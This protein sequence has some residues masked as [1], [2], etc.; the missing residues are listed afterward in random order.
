MFRTGRD[1]V[2]RRRLEA[3]A[4]RRDVVFLHRLLRK[5]D[6]ESAVRIQPRDLKRLVRALEVFFLTG[7]PLTAHF[8]E[9]SRRS[10][11]DVLAIGLRLPAER[12]PSASRARRR[13]V[14]RGFRRDPD[15]A[16]SGI[17]RPRVRSAVG[18]R[19]A[20]EPARRA[21]ELATRA[22]IAQETA[23]MRAGS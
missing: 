4:E 13:A 7:R 6:A 5:V 8:A 16:A 2:L 18:Y 10:D 14:A 20:M 22:L 19:Q 15:A 12:M 21:D 1:P 11:V 17:P 3:I 23:A 9:R